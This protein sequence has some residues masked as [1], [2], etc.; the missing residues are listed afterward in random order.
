MK[1]LISECLRLQEM[2]KLLARTFLFSETK[3]TL[4]IVFTIV[5]FE[6]LTT[7]TMKKTFFWNVTPCNMVDD[8]LHF[9]G[10][11]YLHHQD[12]RLS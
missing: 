8:Y 7:V 11:C 3:N 6:V 2:R 10:T 9:G 4:A 5:R 1:F 12:M